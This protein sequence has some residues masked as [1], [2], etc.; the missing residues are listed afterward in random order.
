KARQPRSPC[1]QASRTCAAS[2]PRRLAMRTPR[3][4]MVLPRLMRLGLLAML[5]IVPPAA[6]AGAQVEE[7]LAAN[8]QSLLHRSVSDYPA[9]HLVF[10]TDIEGLSWLAD[11]S[12][13]LAGKVPDWTTRRD[14]LVTVQY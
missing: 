4:G 3:M 7:E 8:V 6:L 9:P 2:R 5:A 11:M 13:R 14:F 12:S 10:A 1:P